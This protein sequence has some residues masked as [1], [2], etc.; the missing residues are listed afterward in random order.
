M[1]WFSYRNGFLQCEEVNLA[2]IAERFGTPLYVYS[3]ATILDHYRRLDAAFAAIDHRICYAVKANSNAAILRLLVEAGAGFDIVSGGE[4]FRVLKAGADPALCSF[5]GVGK[6]VAEISFALESGIGSFNVESEAELRVIAQIAQKKG[7]RAPIA[8]RINPDVI[9]HTHEYISTGTRRNK[10]GIP[11][12]RAE[13]LY[14]EAAKIP[15]IRLCGLHIHIGSQIKETDPFVSAIEKV[16]PLVRQLRRRHAIEFFSIGGG[17]G[18]PYESSLASGNAGWWKQKKEA[19]QLTLEGYAAAILP[20]LRDLGLRIVLEPGRVLVGNSGVLLTRV[21]YRKVSGERTFVIV[22]AG[23]ND[24]IRPALYRSYHEIVPIHH[25]PDEPLEI[26]DVVGPVCESSDFFALERELSLTQPGALLALMSAGAYGFTMASNYNSR[27]LPAEVL[28]SG[29]QVR[30]IR[31][32]QS[33]DDLV[34]DE[35]P[36]GGV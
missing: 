2:E 5:A 34:R 20:L 15:V 28:V 18:I 32:R 7:L 1:H 30:L 4:L 17:I 9:T 33:Y 3:E 10:F 19:S 36:R 16:L 24:L 29:E 11:L 26:V 35:R 31:A 22:D 23:M 21:L 27:L 25:L 8:L 12:D 14:E 6:T 13:A